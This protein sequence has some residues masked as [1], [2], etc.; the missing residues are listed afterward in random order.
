MEGRGDKT[1]DGVHTHSEKITG[2]KQIR[3]AG[4]CTG[5]CQGEAKSKTF[6]TT[7]GT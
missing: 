5:Y 4:M 2:G 3:H 6:I 1:R 7:F